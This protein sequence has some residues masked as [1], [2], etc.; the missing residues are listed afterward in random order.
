MRRSRNCVT[1]IPSAPVVSRLPARSGESRAVDYL[2]R[3]DVAGDRRHAGYTGSGWTLPPRHLPS[4]PDPCLPDSLRN[5]RCRGDLGT[6]TPRLPAERGPDCAAGSAV[7]RHLC[8]SATRT[9]AIVTA[10]NQTVRETTPRPPLPV[11]RERGGSRA[12]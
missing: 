6:A 12:G 4:P 5:G 7:D 1:S 11:R 3:A 9:T 8:P 2:H 10:Q